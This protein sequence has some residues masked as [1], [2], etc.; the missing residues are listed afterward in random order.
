MIRLYQIKV[1]LWKKQTRKK[2][3]TRWE[4]AQKLYQLIPQG[5]KKKQK[6]TLNAERWLEISLLLQAVNIQP[7]KT[8]IPVSQN[9]YAF[10]TKEA[11]TEGNI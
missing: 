5:G 11:L 8:R 4:R 3:K 7:S 6:Q 1:H 9:P 10:S 2:N